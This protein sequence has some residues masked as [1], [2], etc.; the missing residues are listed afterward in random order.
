MTLS[1]NWKGSSVSCRPPGGTLSGISS[2]R[3]SLTIRGCESK[4]F[5]SMFPAREFAPTLNKAADEGTI[6]AEDGRRLRQSSSE[7]TRFR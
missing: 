6:R 4:Q 1:P 5:S 7:A 2:R 3:Q